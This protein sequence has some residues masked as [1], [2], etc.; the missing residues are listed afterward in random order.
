MERLPNS[1]TNLNDCDVCFL[2]KNTKTLH[3]ST[4]PRAFRHLENVHVDLSGIIRTKGL[5]NELY[6]ALFCDDY[7]SYRHIYFLQSKTKEEVLS[8]FKVYLAL[9]ERQTCM[10]LKQF[11]LDRGGEFVN[12]LLGNELCEQGVVL[13]LKASHSPEENGVSERGN[14]T[15]S[16]KARSMMFESSMPLRFWVQACKTAVFLT[17]RT[18]TCALSENRTPFEAW[19]YRE[20]SVNHVRVFG[21]LS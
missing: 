8:V 20:P 1:L 5:N 15:I 7:S 19:H 10:K 13:H 16:T 11:T 14:R 12:D 2:S 9:A 3:L 17:N 4:R 21:C 6:Y 18:I